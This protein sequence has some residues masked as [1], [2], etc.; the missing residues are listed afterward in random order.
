MAKKKTSSQRAAREHAAATPRIRATTHL[1]AP[2][3]PKAY[4]KHV[5]AVADHR[6]EIRALTAAE[7]AK[8]RPPVP[9]DVEPPPARVRRAAQLTALASWKENATARLAE[10]Q[11]MSTGTD[12]VAIPTENAADVAKLKQRLVEGLS[13]TSARAAVLEGAQGR[14]HAAAKAAR[15]G[16]AVRLG[17]AN[18]LLGRP[19]A[20]DARLHLTLA[21]STF[22][23]E[24]NSPRLRREIAAASGA[25]P[26]SKGL[27]Y[28][29]AR[30][31][32]MAG[33]FGSA[34]DLAA[35]A[36]D[37]PPV[38]HDLMPLIE[39]ES[40]QAP[41]LTWPCN[42]YTYRYSLAT[43]EELRGM[44][45]ALTALENDPGIVNTWVGLGIPMATLELLKL[46]ARA[47]RMALGAL[48]LWN[49]ANLDMTHR[50]YASAVRNYEECQRAI[51]NYFIV[52][53]PSIEITPPIPPDESGSDLTPTSQLE[54]ALETLASKLIN[55]NAPT[56]QIWTYFRERHQTITLDELYKHDWRRPN[57][58]PLSYEFADPLPGEGAATDFATA[59][60]RLL[61]R[62]GILK[63]LQT[64]GEKVE[65]KL[66]GPLLAIA[67]VLCA[68][69]SAEANRMRRQ[70]DDALTQCRQLQRRHDSHRLLSEVIEKPFVKVLKAQVIMDKADAQYK[71]RALSSSPATNPDDTL[72]YQGLEAAETYQGV[73]AV[74]ED[75]GQYVNRVNAGVDSASAEL[76]NLLQHTFHPVAAREQQGSPPP[77]G[78]AERRALALTGKKLVIETMAPRQGD[79][80][81]P[82]RRIRPHESLIR[83][84][85]PDAIALRETNPV[86][87]ALIIE[88]RA[89]LLQMASGLNYLGYNDDY[90][91]PW[92][93]QFLLDRARYFAEHAK[94]AQR[95]YLN[96]LN[97][98]EREEF[99]ELTAS[100]GVEMEKSNIRIESAR[101]DHSRAELEASKASRELAELQAD[102]SIRRLDE[103]TAM[104]ARMRKLEQS[105]RFWG[106]L[107]GMGAMIA[108]IAAAPV[109]GGASVLFAAGSL[110][111]F[112]GQTQQG[113]KQVGMAR[114]QRAYEKFNLGLAVGEA[115]QGALVAHRQVEVAQ[116][117]LL[118]AG[119]QR[120]AAVLRHEF[121]LHSLMFLRNRA[122]NAELWYRLA[123]AVRGVADLYLRYGIE[124][125]FLAEQAYEFEAD[126]RLD[127]VRFDY[128]VSDLGDLLAGDF[129]LRDL[130][131]LEQDLI[132]TQ[133]VRQQQVRYVVSMAREFPEALQELRSSGRTMFAMRLEQL[134]RRFPGLFNLRISAVEVLPLALMDTSRF[135]LELTHLGMGALRL[136]KHSSVSPAGETL[137]PDWL[138]GLD[139]SWQVRLRST[140]PE[141]AIYSGVVRSELG[142]VASFFAANQRGAF[143]GL[144][145][146]SAW[147]IDM[148]MRENRVVPDSLAD[149]Q[150]VLTLSGYYDATLRD[151][152][153]HAPQR[154]LAAT[155]WLSAH[156]SFPDAFYEFSRTGRM[157]WD[158]TAEDLALQGSA[159]TLE[160]LALFFVPSLRTVE[161][162][163]QMCS[164]PIEFDVDGA[165]TVTLLRAPPAISFTTVGLALD[166]TLSMPA[167]STVTFD[168]GDETGLQDSAALP[169]TYARPGRYEVLVRIAAD[170]RL[171][172]YRADVV[173]SR[174]HAV[175]A[176]CVALPVLQTAVSGGKVVL[177]PSLQVPSGEALTAVWQMDHVLSDDAPG[178]VRFTLDPGRYVLRL[179]ALR[180]LT[181][182]FH[183]RQRHL[184][185][186]T[187]PAEG[188]FLTTNREFD[189]V[190]GNELPTTAN[191][192]TQ[193]VFGGGPVS[194]VDRWT[195]ELN[196][197]DNPQFAS[198]TTQD[199]LQFELGELSDVFLALEFRAP[200]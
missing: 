181:A 126:K 45:E 160:N 12:G 66:D 112:I 71:A 81:D 62:M 19:L 30:Y 154:P 27:A 8:P 195:L 134:E 61:L 98:A 79:Y 35:N 70:F 199:A 108:G 111:S 52:R 22:M 153:E 89:R 76:V 130:D 96:F 68:L 179:R 64:Y 198:V 129:L 6:L 135:S 20:P 178:P 156:Q 188:L 189:E 115:Q 84:V 117:G 88:A 174:D 109:T 106:A 118:V 124:M 182:R 190:T 122:L 87:Y 162:G 77:L 74:F 141:T 4:L 53:Y 94:N 180:P 127:V 158:V 40:A 48:L 140:A 163:R 72:K 15:H 146:C 36:L 82:D 191:G 183:S 95:E 41:W 42:F 104:D 101:V 28:W 114:E 102:H 9:R 155:N 125:A 166:A 24:G 185:S 63:S 57:V 116:A 21:H 31:E 168:F 18:E 144:A 137:A 177:T 3:E 59:L 193:H 194:P 170:G 13:K 197:G 65:E 25:L 34:R 151:A 1:A 196:L 10:L 173:V 119:M 32:L 121:A 44:Q 152:V 187:L 164:Y 148:S 55:Y 175:L 138:V 147:R 176:P 78:A 43:T 60:A 73:L 100:Q 91:P 38:R 120:A 92:R 47:G 159:G 184:P 58:V 128:D 46:R 136:G 67:L 37:Y 39:P 171:T 167:G 172:E 29:S 99:Q 169:H 132:V 54:S 7:L 200:Q 93:F 83:F 113:G 14:W 11:N 105:S 123:S 149:V 2:R 90:V 157:E 142:G 165:G 110:A 85:A 131:T 143:E 103:Y 192:F 56:R 75:Q 133:R 5:R 17:T 186:V 139:D 23:L 161:L 26:K 150:L 86:I 97:N 33:N 107:G 49:Q 69:A 50:K 145:A 80:P 16:I 51:V